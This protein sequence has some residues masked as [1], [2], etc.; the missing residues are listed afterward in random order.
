[1]IASSDDHAL[2]SGRSSA[3]ALIVL[4]L[5]SVVALGIWLLLKDRVLPTEA[6]GGVQL[7][8]QSAEIDALLELRRAEPREA[9]SSTAATPPR[10]LREP[11]DLETAQTFFPTLTR[12]P[13][14]FADQPYV[15][16]YP[17]EK[18]WWRSWAEHPEGG[19]K[20][21]INSRGMLEE[22]DPSLDRPD[23][24]VLVTGDSHTEG[25]CA[26]HETFPNVLE[27][28]L[29]SERSG[30]VIEVLNAG[31]HGYTL[32]NY[33]GVLEANLDLQPDVF[34]ACFYGG[35]DFSGLMALQRYFHRR[36]PPSWEPFPPRAL[37][38]V[39][40]GMAPQEFLQ[41]CYFLNNP[42]DVDVAVETLERG[43]LEILEVCRRAGAELVIVYLPPPTRGQPELEE[44]WV[45][46]ML[47]ER[48]G[49]EIVAEDMLVSDEIADRW[50][51]ALRRAE[52][53]CLDLRPIF[54]AESE[55]LYWHGDHHINLRAHELIAEA[56]LPLVRRYGQSAR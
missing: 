48:L 11:L 6:G 49:L 56:L 35:N 50:L 53:T 54:R 38:G 17:T 33:L 8:D 36:D 16:R 25:V 34:V 24:R 30:Q 26:T 55:P 44:H 37:K 18:R 1:M 20:H 41:A 39:G 23:L 2:Q 27:A 9:V 7:I 28:M 19:W 42:E 52:I 5:S 29:A 10:L 14:F 3:V 4:A 12:R 46:E 43:S 13:E 22:N 31:H 21:H 15:Y 32:Y 47:G 51:A 40:L 45:E